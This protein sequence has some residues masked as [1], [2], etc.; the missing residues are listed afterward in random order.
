MTVGGSA[1]TDGG[2]GA[3]DALAEAGVS[4]RLE[5]LCDVRTAWEDAPRTFAPQKGADPAAVAELERRLA[6]LA[7]AA[8]GIPAAC[9]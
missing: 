8:P 1:T 3:L 2:A 5:V 4:P 7:A 6:R 9:P